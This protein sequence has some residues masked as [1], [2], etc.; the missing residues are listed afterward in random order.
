MYE[1]SVSPDFGARYTWTGVRAF[2][3]D[4][5]ELL[6]AAWATVAYPNEDV[7]WSMGGQGARDVWWDG[8]GVD[9]KRAFLGEVYVGP[10]VKAMRLGFMGARRERQVRLDKGVTHYALVYRHDG[11][12][13]T[14]EVG[15][16][17]GVTITGPGQT[18]STF[19]RHR[20]SSSSHLRP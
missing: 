3:A 20:Q 12:T 7:M 14:A 6:F 13:E 5:S 9:V 15:A 17:S 8:V 16:E 19:S 4:V 1:E 11:A 2:R 10:G 18:R